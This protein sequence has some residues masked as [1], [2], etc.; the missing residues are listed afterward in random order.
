MDGLIPTSIEWPLPNIS[1][2]ETVSAIGLVLTDIASL[3]YNIGLD[4][5]DMP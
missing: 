1:R 4:G 5:I 2:N 3:S